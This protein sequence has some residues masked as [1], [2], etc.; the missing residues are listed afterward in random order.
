MGAAFQGSARAFSVDLAVKPSGALS[1]DYA[2]AAVV[3]RAEALGF[4]TAWVLADDGGRRDVPGLIAYLTARTRSINLGARAAFFT[5]GGDAATAVATLT[6]VTGGRLRLAVDG[7]A[8]YFDEEPGMLAPAPVVAID[9]LACGT[10]EQVSEQ[11]HG[12]RGFSG[13]RLVVDVSDGPVASTLADHLKYLDR[14]ALL[15]GLSGAVSDD[16]FDW[17]S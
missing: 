7:N 17:I 15:A 14:V 13:S 9:G 3:R 6:A 8:A 11:I 10:P 2:I 1:S 4:E 16:R 12:G 5:R